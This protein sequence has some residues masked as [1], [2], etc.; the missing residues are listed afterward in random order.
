MRGCIRMTQ[1]ERTAS[2][3]LLARTSCVILIQ[4]RIRLLARDQRLYKNDATGT[5]RLHEALGAN[6]H[7][8]DRLSES[9]IDGSYGGVCRTSYNIAFHSCPESGRCPSGP[10]RSF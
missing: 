6:R 5:D 2:T 8:L 1:L 9:R 4:P 10:A 3:R 7:P